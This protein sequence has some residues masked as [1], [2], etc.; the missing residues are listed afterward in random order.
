M[1]QT[2]G[3]QCYLFSRP[4]AQYLLE[5]PQFKSIVADMSLDKNIDAHVGKCINDRSNNILYRV[6]CL[7]NHSLGENNSSMGYK[8]NRINLK[9]DYFRGYP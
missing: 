9:T 5:D 7:V 3:A 2:W 8:E 1:V 4:Q 6:P